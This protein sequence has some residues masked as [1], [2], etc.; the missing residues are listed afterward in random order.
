MQPGEVVVG[1]LNGCDGFASRTRLIAFDAL[2]SD[3]NAIAWNDV[4]WFN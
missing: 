3:E 2:T 4:V 1:L